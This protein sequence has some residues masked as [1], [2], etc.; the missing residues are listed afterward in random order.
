[1]AKSYSN[2]K[3]LTQIAQDYYLSNLS[4]TE[5][6]DK[7]KQS[8]YLIT[9]ALDEA[10]KAGIVSIKINAPIARNFQLEEEFKRRFDIPFVSIVKDSDN[11]DKDYNNIL[12]CAAERIQ[13]LIENSHI[14][15]MTWGSTIYSV[16]EHF[17]NTLRD[18]LT[19]TQFIGENMKYNSEAGSRRM[20]ERAASHYEA[21]FL[22]LP[23][24]LYIVNDTIRN[25]LPSEPA[26]RTTLAAARRMDFLFC[27]LGTIS[28]FNSIQTWKSARNEILPSVNLND[29]AGILYARPYDINGNFLTTE[30][31]TTTGLSIEEILA[32]PRRLGIVRSKFKTNAALGA[33]RGKLLTDIVMSEGIA[34]RILLADE[35]F[36]K[37]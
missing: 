1:M 2:R 30:K 35:E 36:K 13:L 18:D 8:R 34:Q 28:S 21:N 6:S 31:D 19:F 26:I 25:L 17:K 27:G 32:T 7:Y 14:V 3:K 37:F 23:L 10:R 24:P 12:E 9:K 20:V 4:V 11:G 16:I 22:T 29:I 5:L 15:G 33:L